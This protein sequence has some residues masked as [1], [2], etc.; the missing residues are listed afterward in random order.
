MLSSML[1]R[2]PFL[3][4]ML[5]SAAVTVGGFGMI[6]AG[7]GF[8]GGEWSELYSG[9]PHTFWELRPN[10]DLDEVPHRE[11]GTTFSVHTNDMGLRDGPTSPESPWVLA[12]GCSTTFGW[13]VDA[14]E[15]WPEVLER[16]L[17]VEVV[18]A[19]VPGHST[20]QGLQF[21]PRLLSLRPKVAIFA[22]GLRDGDLAGRPDSA[23][24]APQFPR[25]T[26]I[27][28]W[29]K[30]R[31]PTP[32]RAAGSVARVGPEAFGNNLRILISRAEAQGTRVLLLDMSTSQSHAQ[33]LDGLGLPVVHLELDS[34]HR[35]ESD[36]VHFT[37]SG[38]AAIAAQVEAATRAA[39][40]EGEPPQS[41]PPALPRTP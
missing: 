33:V 18:N 16:G 25:N 22:W 31:L 27:F 34:G 11:E 23:I 38:N 15:A 40:R 28:T 19:G 21:A 41:A 20:H 14:D 5:L 10:L 8:W 2:S 37:V 13:G 29:L 6:E 1:K 24:K 35:F 4:R 12:L 39:L 36:P 32:E 17:G 30:D 9:S 26:R 3:A 7:L